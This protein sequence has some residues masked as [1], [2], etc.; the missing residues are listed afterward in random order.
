MAS[1]KAAK[2]DLRKHL[3]KILSS[4]P[5]ESLTLQSKTTSKAQSFLWPFL[6]N[7]I[8]PAQ[9]ILAT[10][11][12]L[13]EYQQAKRISIYLS[14]PTAEVQTSTLV[15]HALSNNKR[16][17]VPYCYKL[18]APIPGERASI[19]D[20]LEL[21]SLQDY[22]SLELDAWGIPTPSEETLI[23]RKNCFGGWGKSEGMKVGE[24]DPDEEE[25][26]LVVTPGLGFDKELG[27]IG[28]G[29]SF[30]DSFFV[31]C[32]NFSREGKAPWKG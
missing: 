29:M 27:R 19:M 17:F 18:S 10:L 16:V 3:K 31:R 25:L 8:S 28:R 1:I 15:R 14:M 2:N 26:E 21:H 20:M 24:G 12:H 7:P 4:I 9:T 11:L 22:E 32:G 5:N 6:T 23:E 30:Y 13:P